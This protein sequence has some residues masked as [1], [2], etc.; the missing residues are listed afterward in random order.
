MGY[1][2]KLDFFSG[3]GLFLNYDDVASVAWFI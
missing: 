2:K 1:V 3:A